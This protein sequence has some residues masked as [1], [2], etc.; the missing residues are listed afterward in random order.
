MLTDVRP[1][2]FISHFANDARPFSKF[3]SS[4]LKIFPQVIVGKKVF[5]A[6]HKLITFRFS[7]E[8]YVLKQY[9]TV[10]ITKLR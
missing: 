8:N 6:F 10:L 1:A 7:M 3:C 5:Q 2:S 4:L 9:F